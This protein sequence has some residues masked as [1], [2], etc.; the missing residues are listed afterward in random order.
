MEA[1]PTLTQVPPKRP[2]SIAMVF[3]PCCPLALRPQ[4]RPPLPP[5]ITKKSHSFVMG[6]INT[7]GDENWRVS[8]VSLGSAV[9]PVDGLRTRKRVE[10]DSLTAV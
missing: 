5:P 1:Y 9:V 3:A 8:V 6:A 10:G 4:A 2:L 7:E